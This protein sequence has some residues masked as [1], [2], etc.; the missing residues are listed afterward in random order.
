MSWQSGS[1]VAEFGIVLT[2]RSSLVGK[3]N[4]AKN[5]NGNGNGKDKG[6]NEEKKKNGGDAHE[7]EAEKVK[8]HTHYLHKRHGT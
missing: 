6:K 5:G 3:A 7:G 4:G 2:V 8:D 1:V